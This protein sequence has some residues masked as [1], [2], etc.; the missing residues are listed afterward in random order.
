MLPFFIR[1]PF[2][3]IHESFTYNQPLRKDSCCSLFSP[4]TFH[5]L[6]NLSLRI[7]HLADIAADWE[8]LA[9]RHT[10][11]AAYLHHDGRAVLSLWG[12][13]FSDRPDPGPPRV[14]SLVR[15]LQR[16]C[17]VIGGC[18]THWAEGARDSLAG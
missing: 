16:G 5:P 9:A 12:F 6:L 2:D 14:E 15:D 7:S 1:T 10:G 8:K 11:S 18:P 4:K 13:G 3:N 17:Y